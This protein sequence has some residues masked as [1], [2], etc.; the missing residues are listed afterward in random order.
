[1]NIDE[2]FERDMDDLLIWKVYLARRKAEGTR[3]AA[4]AAGDA[5][6]VRVAED[7]MAALPVIA[8]VDGLR[9]A[10]GLAGRLSAQRWIA[11]RDAEAQGVPSQQITADLAETRAAARNFIQRRIAEHRQ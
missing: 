8:P 10:D 6:G 2:L 7:S 5:A 9:A 11:V 3:A 4:E 1:M